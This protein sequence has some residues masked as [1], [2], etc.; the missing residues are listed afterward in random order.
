LLIKGGLGRLYQVT[1]ILLKHGFGY[2]LRDL[3]RRRNL[4]HLLAR[5]LR[6]VLEELG[7]IFV[8]FG[9]AV[10]TRPELLPPPFLSELQKLQDSVEPFPDLQAKE[11]IAEDL[12]EKPGRLFRDFESDPVAS[13]SLAQVYR[14]TLHDGRR[15][16]VKVRRPGVKERL[17]EDIGILYRLAR[18]VEGLAPA[19][20]RIRMRE[21]VK[22]FE[23]SIEE[24]LDFNR[25]EENARELR[26]KTEG[27]GRI[28]VPETYPRYCSERVLTS[29]WLEGVKISQS[30]TL[31][32]Q[33]FELEDLAETVGETY[34]RQ[35][36]EIGTF[37]SDPHPGNI[38]VL[39]EGELGL[40][41]FGTLGRLTEKRRDELK[42]LFLTAAKRDS[43]DLARLLVELQFLSG[44]E[45]PQLQ[46]ELES[47]IENYY[48]GRLSQIKVGALLYE[49]LNRI[50]RRY[51]VELPVE[52]LNLS[53]TAIMV[54]NICESLD[55]NY[56]WPDTVSKL[57]PLELLEEMTL[58]QW[59]EKVTSSA[60]IMLQLPAKIDRVLDQIEGGH[61]S[62]PSSEELEE[63][64][65]GFTPLGSSA[66]LALVFSATL[67]SSS[68]LFMEGFFYLGLS[69]FG[70][71]GLSGLGLMVKFLRTR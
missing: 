53:R 55:P 60:R 29:E 19:T 8:K 66:A 11:I 42:L 31:S 41:D 44:E 46:K 24:E 40:V 35:I 9:Q 23:L 26:E 18:T 43:K 2:F 48:Q 15:V 30:E 54:E 57:Y 61:I 36:L 20:R 38:L 47:L 45:L 13:A 65:Q 21:A 39:A 17:E 12:G 68:M 70:L 34:L 10:S 4:V 7:P 27:I 14:A 58:R 5:R 25:E 37:H 50:V 16:A 33:G 49:F 22:E 67:I 62:G 3:P 32:R 69:G 51:D 1:L 52:Y 63:L 56:R 28:K 6:R 71:S 59:R 64:A